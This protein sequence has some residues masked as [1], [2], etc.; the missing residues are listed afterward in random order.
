MSFGDAG[1]I[2]S[3]GTQDDSRTATADKSTLILHR[4]APHLKAAALH[5]P[6]S[7]GM[8]VACWSAVTGAW[9]CL[10]DM[11]TGK[12]GRGVAANRI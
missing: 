7:E 2:T 1:M 12:S 10:P 9:A 11:A 6:W 5:E 3:T 4:G 8:L